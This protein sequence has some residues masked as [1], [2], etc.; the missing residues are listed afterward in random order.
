MR[1][2]YPIPGSLVLLHNLSVEDEESK[3]VLDQDEVIT[4]LDVHVVVWQVGK[5]CIA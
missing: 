4:W 2:S 1:S 5:Y 3:G